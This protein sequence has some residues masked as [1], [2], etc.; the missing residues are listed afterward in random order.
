[1]KI[2]Y[3]LSQHPGNTGSGVYLK[4]LTKEAIKDNNEVT[5]LIGINKDFN[6]KKELNHISE[7]DIYTV[8]FNSDAL[9]FFIPGMSD[10]MP[11]KSSRFRDLN[12][13]QLKLYKDAF[14][15][16]L[17]EIKKNFKPDIIHS[18]HLWILSSL[19]KKVFPDT[20]LIVSCHGTELRQKEFCPH[21]VSMI[22]EDLKK[23]DVIVALTENQKEEILRWLE[24]NGNKVKVLGAAYSDE[25]FHCKIKNL[26]KNY[27]RICYAGKIS[28]AKGVPYLIEAFNRIKKFKNLKIEL[29]LAGGYD[30]EEGKSIVRSANNKNIKFLG[31]ISQN[32][33]AEL[34][35]NSNLFILPSFFEG[36][37]LVV[38]EALACGC[39]VIVTELENVKNWFDE[40]FL[41]LNAV[42]F[43]P[44]PELK[45][46]DEINT[47]DVDKFIK[48]IQLQIEKFVEN[49]LNGNFPEIEKI[50]K[51]V[52]NHSYSELFNKL[53]NIYKIACKK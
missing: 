45:N 51:Y 12:D 44:L 25:I 30:N 9:P 11:Y 39:G 53:K 14:L 20:P 1:M 47:K 35:R 37:P 34:F 15:N 46:V 48:N 7:K 24:I 21:I 41:K 40:D 36:L 8:Q 28:K 19:I 6:Y 23:I 5:V 52:K 4:W 22:E 50:T 49:Y 10:V 38:L 42:K 33:L 13:S 27:F 3:A 16:K 29:I 17:N 2:L 18:N 43:I 31:N 26:Q 32:E